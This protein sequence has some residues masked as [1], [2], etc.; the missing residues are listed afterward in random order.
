MRN[1]RPVQLVLPCVERHE[2]DLDYYYE[3]ADRHR[4]QMTKNNDLQKVYVY[5]LDMTTFKRPKI[6]CSKLMFNFK[7]GFYWKYDLATYIF[8]DSFL[9]SLFDQPLPLA[10]ELKERLANGQKVGVYTA[11][12]YR[13]FSYLWCYLK[14]GKGLS[15]VKFRPKN[16]KTADVELKERYL[17]EC[18]FKYDYFS[19][20]DIVAYDDNEDIL[21][22][23][24]QNEIE[25]YRP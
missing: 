7:R 24:R 4:M 18:L 14:I 11:R 16:D 5:D 12:Q 8:W 25:C 17:K 6:F 3:R 23:Y 19:F 9:V 1:K 13:W 20:A 15:F 10:K 22:M 2:A 21:S